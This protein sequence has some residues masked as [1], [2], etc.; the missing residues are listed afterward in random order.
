MRSRLVCIWS[1]AALAGALATH[2]GAQASLQMT[3][4]IP[5]PN[6]S[7]RIDHLAFD[8][9]RHRLFVAALGHNTVEV[10][11]TATGTHLTSI[12]GFSEPQ[13]IAVAPDTRT[14][15]IANGGTGM[16]MGIDAE[17]L[18]TRWSIPIGGDADNVRYDAATHRVFVAAE[19]GLTSVDPAAGR[20]LQ[21][22]SISGHPES[23][24]LT[25][26]AERIVANLPDASTLIAADGTRMAVT[27]QWPAGSCGANYPMA[28]DVM[29]RRVFVGC[30]RPAA[31]AMF[32]LDSG[33]MLTS[34]PAVGDADDL[35]FDSGRQRIYVIGGDGF[36]DVF[37]RKA[38][39]LLRSARVPTAGGART[40]LWVAAQNRLYVAVPARGS[41]RA[42]VR[43]FDVRE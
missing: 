18:R 38:D 41:Q 16:L 13:G 14:V 3:A 10:L 29:A 35:F 12:P 31:V 33:R 40:G 43:V 21:R 9:D 8:A 30:R 7:G 37:Q 36:V 42:E 26:R 19:G 27:A 39:T 23:F 5:L 2:V 24:Q 17:T 11:D 6:V 22:I 34:V 20:I 4:S 25:A 28:I 1:A 15:A 32:D